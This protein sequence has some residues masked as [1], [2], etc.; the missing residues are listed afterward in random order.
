MTFW[1]LVIPMA[2]LLPGVLVL[3]HSSSAHFLVFSSCVH[4]TD[5]GIH[6]GF[7][8]NFMLL[9]HPIFLGDF[10]QLHGFCYHLKGGSSLLALTCVTQC[11]LG[12]SSW[13]SL[14]HFKPNMSELNTSSSSTS[15]LP[16]HFLELLQI[17]SLSSPSYLLQKSGSLLSS[18]PSSPN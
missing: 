5:I 15:W 2:L 16:I 10:I 11:F 14:K 12:S 17:T 13:M 3:A 1:L 9:N 6:C 4:I 8:Y 18:L 7:I